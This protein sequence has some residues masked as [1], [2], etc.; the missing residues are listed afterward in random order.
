MNRGCG[1]AFLNVAIKFGAG[2][3]DRIA[4]MNEPGKGTV[5]AHQVVNRFIAPDCRRERRTAVGRG[6]QGRE[7][8]LIGV[9]ESGA[10]GVG[11]VEVALDR[12]IVEAAIK[13]VEIPLRQL[14]KTRMTGSDCML[15]G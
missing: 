11:V 5:P 14:A 3:I 10:F 12:R 2:G 8:A 9:L 7:L 6:R 4:G 1:E 15:G 13:V